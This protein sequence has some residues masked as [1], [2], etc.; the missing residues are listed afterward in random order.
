MGSSRTTNAKDIRA[1]ESR[2]FPT[3]AISA[4]LN[5]VEAD[6]KKIIAL[7]GEMFRA[8]G[9]ALYSFDLYAN[10]AINRCLALSSGFRVMILDQN[11]ICAGALLRLQLDTALR[12]FAGFLVD[13]PHGF[14]IEVLKGNRINKMLDKESKR[15]TDA[16]LVR[17][18]AET[19]PW[20]EEI[21]D[22]ASG[23]VHMS[24][25]HMLSTV[26]NVDKESGIVE[27]KASRHDQPLTDK[28]YLDTI[29]TFRQCTK[30]LI[31]HVEGWIVTKSNPD[32][33]A[34]LAEM[35]KTGN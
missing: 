10:A 25:V 30:V 35:K 19:Y 26:S 7:C 31:I 8:Y 32:I 16:Y 27:L 9:G 11:L 2:D 4:A 34:R 12:F 22:R 13:N 23:Y 17:K 3:E 1:I 6:E 24:E 33:V 21:Y 5:G 20:V 15:M 29:N 28:T 14:A 18:M